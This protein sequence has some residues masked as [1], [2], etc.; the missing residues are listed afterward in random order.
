MVP[1]SLHMTHS[2]SRV[3]NFHSILISL[4]IAQDFMVTT[5]AVRGQSLCYSGPENGLIGDSSRALKIASFCTFLWC[6][7]IESCIFLVSSDD[8]LDVGARGIWNWKINSARRRERATTKPNPTPHQTKSHLAPHQRM[9]LSLNFMKK[10]TIFRPN[11][12]TR[13]KYNFHRLSKYRILNTARLGLS[14]IRALKFK[15]KV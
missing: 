6:L 13:K 5:W 2:R 12:I 1:V 10:P 8:S 3:D 15:F 7:K 9:K 11:S 14:L 4:F